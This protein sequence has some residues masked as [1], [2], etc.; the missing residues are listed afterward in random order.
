MTALAKI[1]EL[2][3]DL[4][5]NDGQLIV[6]PASK[7]TNSCRDFIKAHKLE[8]IQE[9]RSA[10]DETKGLT[11]N[12][13][14]AILNWL[15]FIGENSEPIIND[16][17]SHC[18]NNLDALHYYLARSKELLA[19]D[20]RHFCNSCTRLVKKYCHKHKFRPV[21]DIPRR[22]SDFQKLI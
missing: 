18:A 19:H 5:V 3:F 1:K 7:L 13:R 10:N 4:S 14:Q 22:C 6:I 11:N 8:I 9:L 17:V 12:D 21:D 20:D 16:V 2:G 15:H